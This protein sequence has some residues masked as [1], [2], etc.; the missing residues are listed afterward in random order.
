MLIARDRPREEVRQQNFYGRDTLGR[1]IGS[2]CTA[3]RVG[4]ETKQ[5]SARRQCSMEEKE[6]LSY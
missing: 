2:E 1:E 3:L 6:G 4:G 5:C